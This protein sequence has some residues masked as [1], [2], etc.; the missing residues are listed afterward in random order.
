[1]GHL[2]VQTV[3][4][5]REERYYHGQ[6]HCELRFAS[7]LHSLV[8][9]KKQ[10]SAQFCV[11]IFQM[12]PSRKK[13]T[14]KFQV[15]C[16]DQLSPVGTKSQVLFLFF[17]THGLQ[18]LLETDLSNG[19]AL[20]FSIL[21]IWWGGEGWELWLNWAKIWQNMAAAA[22]AEAR[23]YLVRLLPCPVDGWRGK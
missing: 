20:E 9:E 22:A 13:N 3:C 16:W 17:L 7:F 8:S 14:K 1:M 19:E 15:W 12:H 10:K 23:L 6:L 4:P 18:E 2:F 11:Q 5:P 21:M